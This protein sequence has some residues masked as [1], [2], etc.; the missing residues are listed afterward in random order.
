MPLTEIGEDVQKDHDEARYDE[1][2]KHGRVFVEED[3]RRDCDGNRELV[4]VSQQSS[5]EFPFS[6]VEFPQSLV[7]DVFCSGSEF[8]FDENIQSAQ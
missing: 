8:V 4:E 6:V 7:W 1:G 5:D 3:R 2:V